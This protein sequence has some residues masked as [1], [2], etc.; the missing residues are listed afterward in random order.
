MPLTLD[1]H[2]QAIVATVQAE[3]RKAISTAHNR[4]ALARRI[5]V[6]ATSA[7]NRGRGAAI[8][9]HPFK[10]I[11]EA[12]GRP[13]DVKHAVLDEMEPELGY[14][15]KVRWVCSRANNSGKHSCGA[16]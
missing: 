4:V 14:A 15:G 13:L 9:S 12:S 2:D 16:C 10:D 5:S 11:C 3:M 8:K 1:A 7:R 6:L